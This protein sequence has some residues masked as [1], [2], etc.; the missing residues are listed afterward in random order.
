MTPSQSELQA[1]K[2]RLNVA[3]K[4]PRAT[5]RASLFLDVAHDAMALVER[6]SRAPEPSAEGLLHDLHEAIAF[7][8]VPMTDAVGKALDNIEAALRRA[9][10]GSRWR[11]IETCPRDSSYILLI[12]KEQT[13]G[14][15]GFWSA[16]D[17]S[18]TFYGP[19][20]AQAAT[21]PTHWQPL[22]APPTKGE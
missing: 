7:T 12:G 22:P 16:R 10:A 20:G 5:M 13:F 17:Q 4:D 21:N 3:V 18:F 11:P 9:P 2:E 6:L 1:L 14:Y 15:T 19:W 8:Q